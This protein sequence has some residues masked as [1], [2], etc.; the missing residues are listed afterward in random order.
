[1]GDQNGVD[2]AAPLSRLWR[3]VYRKAAD[4]AEARTREQLKYHVYTYP[5]GAGGGGG[6]GAGGWSLVEK[7]TVSTPTA[8]VAFASVPAAGDCLMLISRGSVTGATGEYGAY[9]GL[10]FNGDPYPGTTDK[11]HYVMSDV[12][13]VP[14]SAAAHSTTGDD[15]FAYLGFLGA[16]LSGATANDGGGVSIA[17]LPDF[18]AAERLNAISEYQIYHTT[19][20]AYGSARIVGGRYSTVYDSHGPLTALAVQCGNALQFDAGS[21]FA[22]YVLTATGGGGGG[23]G[24]TDVTITTDA[25]LTATESPANTFALAA[26]LSPDAGNAL[27][28]HANGLYSTDTGTGGGGTG[29]TTMHTQTATPTGASNS[30]WFNP[31]ET[32]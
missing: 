22:L 10:S 28:L 16:S 7:V 24:T 1:V 19:L 31:S 29:N 8:R 5:H 12:A 4:V 3:D 23:G 6:G 18:T 27:S 11:Y 25:S 15:R 9:Y 30:L 21:T 20:Y 17:Y 13:G 26:R 32:A 14:G 2:L